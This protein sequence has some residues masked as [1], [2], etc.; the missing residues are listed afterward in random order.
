MRRVAA[1]LAVLAL[2][3]A[4]GCGP[5]PRPRRFFA[6]SPEAPERVVAEERPRIRVAPFE[7][8]DEYAGPVLRYSLSDVE[9]RSYRYNRWV[10]RPGIMVAEAFRRYLAQSGRFVM[11]A[12]GEPADVVLVGRVEV[13]EHAVRD[14]RWLGRLTVSFDLQRPRDGRV[15]LRHRI[16]GEQEAEEQE[17]GAVVTAMSQVL[18][19]GL[20]EVLD[21]LIDAASRAHIGVPVDGPPPSASPP[22]E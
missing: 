17:L 16:D 13:L 5:R 3:A 8:S 9:L 14:G 15:V 18:G 10:V 21:E 1:A 20:D 12:P 7:C 19:E 22:G 6:L 11:V 4:S 2:V